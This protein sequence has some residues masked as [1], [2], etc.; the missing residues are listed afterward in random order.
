M[1]SL[2]VRGIDDEL[3][4]RLKA[5]AA[6]HGRSAEAEHREIL[7]QVLEAGLSKVPFGAMRGQIGMAPDFDEP[8]IDIIDIMESGAV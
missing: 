8:D 5:R 6:A 3:V 1:A 2:I 4:S 7:R